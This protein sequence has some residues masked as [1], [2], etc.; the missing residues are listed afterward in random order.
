M[1]FSV[2]GLPYIPLRREE[3]VAGFRPFLRARP[4]GTAQPAELS[5]FFSL[6]MAVRF[7]LLTS[8]TAFATAVL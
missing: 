5:L 4:K 6:C 3:R 1:V 2:L 7:W 8:C